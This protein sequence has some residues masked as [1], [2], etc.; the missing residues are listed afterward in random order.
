MAQ[1]LRPVTA[2]RVA[3]G[4]GR[5]LVDDGTPTIFSM[6]SRFKPVRGTVST[7]SARLAT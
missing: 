7:T 4:P 2:P 1:H 5:A 6:I 3:G